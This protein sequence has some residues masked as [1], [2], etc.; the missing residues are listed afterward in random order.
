MAESVQRSAR[1][2][3]TDDESPDRQLLDRFVRG[4]DGGAFRSL[5]QRYGPLVFGVCARLL[6]SEHDAEDAYQ[7]TFLVLA[8]KAGSLRAPESLGPWLYG[9]AYRTALKARAQVLRRRGREEALGEPTCPT[10]ADDL[11]WSDLRPIL[12]EEVNRLPH[13]YRAA[14]VLCYFE[15]KTNEQAARILGC[16]PGT[17]FSRLAT[18]RDCLRRQLTRRGLTLSAV[19]LV[20]LLTR[21]AG[22]SPA[23]VSSEAVLAFAAGRPIGAGTVPAPAVTLA[24]GVL[25]VMFVT[26]LK[27]VACVLLAI[28]VAITGAGVI[29]GARPEEKPKTEKGAKTDKDLIQGTWVFVSAEEGGK[30]VPED[31]FKNFEMVFTADKVNLPIKQEVK[32]L[33]YKLDPAKKPKQIDIA[34]SEKEI[35]EGIYELDGDKLKIC[36]TKPD[37]GDR[38]TKFDSTEGRESVLIVLKRKK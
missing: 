37:H 16:P 15:G 30:A 18:A 6:G 20:G 19:A 38:P 32:E 17:I 29:A 28:G 26:K 22:A 5:V 4:A 9:V 23:D 1:E 24:E 11:I 34:F 2:S 7:A 35:A 27:F 10:D 3:L 12:D 31:A 25:R 36:L 13:K 14:V 33:S 21:S 8:R